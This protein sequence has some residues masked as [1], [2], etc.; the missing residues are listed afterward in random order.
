MRCAARQRPRLSTGVAPGRVHCGTHPVQHATIDVAMSFISGRT[1]IINGLARLRRAGCRVHVL[2]TIISGQD[3]R[4][5][6]RARIHP[7]TVCMTP[8]P[9]TTPATPRC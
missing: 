1:R 7:R 5:L 2:T 8:T 6:H 9:T 4:A 3:R